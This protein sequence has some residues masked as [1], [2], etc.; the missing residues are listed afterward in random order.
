MYNLSLFQNTIPSI[1][2]LGYCVVANIVLLQSAVVL[3]LLLLL[4]SAGRV[5]SQPIFNQAGYTGRCCCMS[6]LFICIYHLALL[7]LFVLQLFTSIGK[8][9]RLYTLFLVNVFFMLCCIFPLQSLSPC[10]FMQ[11]LIKKKIRCHY[12]I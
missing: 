8:R 10:I 6:F 2:H 3:V 12:E 11:F 9:I 1:Y 5:I 7:L 4:C